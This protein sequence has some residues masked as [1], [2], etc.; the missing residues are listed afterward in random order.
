MK[1]LREYQSLVVG[2]PRSDAIVLIA[3]LIFVGLVTGWIV[4]T[5]ITHGSAL[6]LIAC[7][8]YLTVGVIRTVEVFL[9]L[10]SQQEGQVENSAT[11]EPAPITAKEREYVSYI[12]QAC[13]V[14]ILVACVGFYVVIE[15]GYQGGAFCYAKP[16][17]YEGIW[18]W[19]GIGYLFQA[20]G[21]IFIEDKQSLLGI[22][23]RRFPLFVGLL[24]IPTMP[25]LR[26]LC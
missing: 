8:I 14:L 24:C 11:T 15:G 20:I 10:E 25:I 23:L 2:A 26:L 5:Y 9:R 18:V 16:F 12:V 1:L 7:A 13:V 19:I 4:K 22:T 6:T 3:N 17:F 21:D